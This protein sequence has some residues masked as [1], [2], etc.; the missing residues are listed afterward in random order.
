MISAG[1]RSAA[2]DAEERELV[3][4][5]GELRTAIEDSAGGEDR[6]G[7]DRVVAAAGIDIVEPAPA[8]DQVVLRR[9]SNGVVA[10][11]DADDEHEVGFRIPVLELPTG[12]GEGLSLRRVGDLYDVGLVVAGDLDVVRDQPGAEL[13]RREFCRG[14]RHRVE[15]DVGDVE[16]GQSTA[17]V[18]ALGD[19]QRSHVVSPGF[20]AD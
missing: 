4:A 18:G 19:G 2:A 16:F 9:P 15:D 14:L 20:A 11:G 17:E 6:A 8:G 1:R 12:G 3:D 10:A 13:G 5:S 7:P